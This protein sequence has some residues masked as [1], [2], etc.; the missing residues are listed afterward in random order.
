VFVSLPVLVED[1][2]VAALLFSRTPRTI[3]QALYGHRR[4]LV[5][6]AMIVGLVALKVAAITAYTIARPIR[7]VIAQAKRGIA[8]ER[9]A[10][11]PLTRPLTRDVDAIS[12]S[13]RDFSWEASTRKY[14]A[15][16][17]G[18]LES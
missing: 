15:I 11:V 1:R 14:L 8:G 2:V 9:R 5:V 16:Y 12:R 7:E 10:M 18:L 4:L 6:S 3:T 17:Q 13:V